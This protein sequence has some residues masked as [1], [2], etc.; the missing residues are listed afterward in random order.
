MEQIP[1]TKTY[2]SKIWSPVLS[3]TLFALSISFFTASG[4]AQIAP[5]A[6]PGHK[7]ADIPRAWRPL[8]GEYGPEQASFIVLEKSGRLVLREHDSTEINLRRGTDGTI[9]LINPPGPP[10]P[11]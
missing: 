1:R 6:F 5:F 7:P 11:A 9:T 8:I 10:L 2:R 3:N 4:F